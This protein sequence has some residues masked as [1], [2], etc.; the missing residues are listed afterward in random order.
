L[1][2]LP[3]LSKSKEKPRSGFAAGLE[4]TCPLAASPRSA[5]PKKAGKAGKAE[6]LH[7]HGDTS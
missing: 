2:I 7:G 4:A 3:P 5:L 1:F 6:I